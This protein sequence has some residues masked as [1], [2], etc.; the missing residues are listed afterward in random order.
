MLDPA[1]WP[2]ET[3]RHLLR[4]CVEDYRLYID[5]MK[6][7]SSRQALWARRVENK[8]NDHRG[9]CA[10]RGSGSNRPLDAD[11][12]SGAAEHKPASSKSVAVAKIQQN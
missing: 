6:A 7:S 2:H 1:G 10:D 5:R 11:N 9:G 3:L 4:R 8:K 12:G